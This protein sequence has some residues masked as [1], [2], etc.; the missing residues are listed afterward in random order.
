MEYVRLRLYVVLSRIALL[1]L[2]YVGFG[3]AIGKYKHKSVTLYVYNEWAEHLAY[4]MNSAHTIGDFDDFIKRKF[5]FHTGFDERFRSKDASRYGVLRLSEA[6]ASSL[7][8]L[9]IVEQELPTFGRPEKAA[10]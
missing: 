7:L 8:T 4:R 5:G 2:V 6:I 3:S 1:P 10:S 9:G